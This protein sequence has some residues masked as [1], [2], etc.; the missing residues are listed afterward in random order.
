MHR[1]FPY[2]EKIHRSKPINYPIFAKLCR[3]EKVFG[4]DKIFKAEHESGQRYRVQILDDNQF[5]ELL[6]RF[7]DS[8][9]RVAAA[10]AGDS[11]RENTGASYLL[12]R[13]AP[14][15]QPE[16]V[17]LPAD[18]ATPAAAAR[19]AVVLENLENFYHL[20]K[21]S[22]LLRRWQPEN[23][24]TAA[25]W[26]FG[27]GNQISNALNRAYLVQ[28]GAMYCL[29]DWDIGGLQIFRNLQT[30]LPQTAVRF[31]LPPEPAE[32]LMK[33]NR[34]LNTQQRSKLA[35]LGGMSPETNRLIAAMRRT[36]R[37]LEQEIYLIEEP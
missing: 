24:F 29:F 10:Q 13:S 30:M 12:R 31:V 36:G 37:S 2:L 25:D 11:H 19:S 1:L 14:L 7:A 27:A 21:M 17:W 9:S 35:E 8:G 6:L 22:A 4:L 33:S 15:W 18:G 23:D 32:Y 5:N 34:L 3:Q 16:L 28:Y 20:D 26:L